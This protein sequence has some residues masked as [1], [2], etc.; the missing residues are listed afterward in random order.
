MKTREF[1]ANNDNLKEDW[2]GNNIGFECPLCA[3]VYVVSAFLKR[4][5][6]CPNCGRSR[7]IVTGAQSKGGKASITW[8]DPPLFVLGRKYSRKQIKAVLGGNE[9]EYLPTQD[10]RVVCGCFTPDH[11]PEAPDI[12]IPGNGPV[13]RREAKQ[14]CAQDW[15][16]PIFIRRRANEWEYV[17]HYKA[18]R[19]STDPADIALH[20]K[21]SITP[22]NQV[23][24]VIFLKAAAR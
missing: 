10:G 8:E 18:E 14:F 11:N 24:R 2:E 12:V 7:G 17:G 22:L 6:H 23:T 19:F 9:I 21:D 1:T 15:P 5:R 13:V 3:K 4:E 16:V 20:H